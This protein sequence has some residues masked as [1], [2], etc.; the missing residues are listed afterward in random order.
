LLFADS[1]Y[2]QQALT[3]RVA[4]HVP[5][6]DIEIAVLSCEDLILHK[7]LAG[8]ILDRADVVALLRANR[9][10]LE[11][12]YLLGWIGQLGL[13]AELEEVWQEAFPGEEQ[14]A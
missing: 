13:T 1:V 4:T 10:T 12:V 11:F 3:R 6:L 14:P 5:G 2:Q 7:L 8:R 9:A